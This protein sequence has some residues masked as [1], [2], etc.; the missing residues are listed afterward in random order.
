MDQNLLLV[1]QIMAVTTEKDLPEFHRANWLK[2]M[3][4]MQLK[5]PGYT[6][7]LLQT[8]LKSYPDFMAA[9]QLAR[10]AAVAKTGGKKSLFSTASFSAMKIQSQIKKD[11]LAAIEA[12]EKALENEPRNP[13]LNQIL[14]EAALAAKLPELAAFALETIIEGS[15]KD[16]K[17]LHEL[18]RHH[19]QFGNPTEAVNLYQKI[20]DI[21][22][23]DM[24]AIKGAKDASA[25]A[26][27]Q[28]GG[29]E[30]EETTY[31]DL[32][33]NKEQAVALEQQ[34]RVVRSDEMIENLLA[35]FH[36]K[37]EA[38]PGNIDTSRRI[39]ELYEQKEDW[40]SA[41]SWF[42]YA[43]ALSNNSDTALVRKATDLQIRQ[44][45]IA[46][47]SREQ[48]IAANP[49]TPESDTYAAELL[50]LLKQK[51]ELALEFAR[52]RVQQNPTDLQFR[53]ELGELLAEL[54]LWQEAIPELQKARQ[55]PNVRTRA[56]CLL[57]RCFTARGMLDLAAKTLS[58]A[59]A[60]LLVMDP[61]KKDVVYNLGLV[62]GK[63]EQNEKSLDCMKQIYEV[64]YGYRDVAARVEGSY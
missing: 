33:K 26:S 16:V 40:D 52:S 3:S 10:K 36:A 49:G 43:A 12:T 6:I 38:E 59:V 9:R 19:L 50:D 15:P 35:E 14:K 57:G 61:V 24:A 32:I 64:D 7:Q 34:S 11:P 30:K 53:F 55:N 46:I 48:Y 63:M 58:D 18:A 28:S 47:S 42:S 37:A 39:A 25:S 20:V 45:G 60:E 62:Y 8:I 44:F 54:E 31:R 41:A 1:G 4:A 21:T 56:M 29:W 22:P 13:Q 51:A 27:M 2:A 5:N 23:N 17:T